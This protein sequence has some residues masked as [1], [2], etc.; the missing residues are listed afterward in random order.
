MQEVIKKRTSIR[1]YEQ[2]SLSSSDQLIVKN[3]LEMFKDRVGPFGHK[4]RFFFIEDVGDYTHKIGTYG[5]IKHPQA[6]IGG[7]V[8]NSKE[9]MIDFGFLMEQIILH[10]TKHNLGTV[11]LGGTYHREDF[12]VDL[13]NDE[14]IAAVSPVGYPKSKSIR[15]RLI[16][17]ISKG[18]QRKPFDELFFSLNPSDHGGL[19]DQYHPYLKAI[20]LAPSASNKQPWRVILSNQTFHLYL[21]RTP[22]YGKGLKIDIQAIDIGIALSHLYLT[23]LED[24]DQVNIVKDDPKLKNE[25]EYILSVI[26]KNKA[27][28]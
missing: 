27:S 18:N 16:R 8:K 22:Q 21:K 3:I 4:V 12:D 24:H 14:I 17:G 5:F 9:G 23:L 13:T 19:M 26:I 20:Q 11:W 1:T 7:V 15:E 10:L 2:K 25:W 28:K 6:F